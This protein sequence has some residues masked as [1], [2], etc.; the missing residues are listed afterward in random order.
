MTKVNKSDAE[1][2]RPERYEIVRKKGTERAFTGKYWDCH[3]QGV[4]RCAAC[5]A[6]LFAS[7]DKFESGSGWPS[8]TKPLVPKA[9]P[10]RPIAR[11]S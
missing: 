2:S 5:K 10:P 11:T 1:S 9:S 7:D 8:F 3:D 4:Y 6:E